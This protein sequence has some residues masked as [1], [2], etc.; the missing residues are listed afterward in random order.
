[1]RLAK[2][3]VMFL[4]LALIWAV[5]LIAVPSSAETAVN[6]SVGGSVLPQPTPSQQ[7]QTLPHKRDC[8]PL[9]VL[10]SQGVDP[11]FGYYY[12]GA[13]WPGMT[14]ALDAAAASVTVTPDLENLAYMLTFDSLW[15]DQRWDDGS[16]TANEMA[17]I[18]DFIATG[19]PVV[20][21]GENDN[22]IPW[23]DQILGVAGGSFAGETN[24]ILNT[25][26]AHPL[27]A[28][29]SQVEV[30]LA[31]TADSG[32]SLFDQNV[33]TIWSGA[34]NDSVLTILDV[35]AASEAWG[36]VDN[37]VF[38]TNVASWVACP[39][40][41][42]PQGEVLLLNE[43]CGGSA[44]HFP[45]ALSNLGVTFTETND[46]VA[47]LAELTGGTAWH[48]VIVDEYA[49]WLSAAT[50]AALVDY[51]A[52]GGRAFMSYWDW[53]SE[54]AL[55]AA[56]E[57]TAV[58]TYSAPLD[59]YRWDVGHPLFNVPNALPDLIPTDD[60]CGNDGGIFNATGGGVTIGGYT[61]G[62]A[63]D[64]HA[65]IVGN[66]GRTIAFGGMPGLFNGDFDSRDGVVDGL[67]LAENAVVWL[68][69]GHA[70]DRL[71]GTTGYGGTLSTLVE[72]DPITGAQ[73]AEIGPVGFVVNGLEFDPT[74]GKLFAGT[75]FGDP[76][77]NG[78]IEIDPATGAGTPIGVHGWGLDPA[79]IGL[80]NITVNAAGQMFGWVEGDDDLV[81]IDKGTGVA[82]VVGDSGLSTQEYGMSF[83]NTDTLFLVNGGGPYFEIDPVTGVATPRGNLG[84]HAHHG[85]FQP[86]TNLYYGLTFTFPDR[87]LV[88]ADLDGGSVIE[89]IPS[90]DTLHTLT[91]VGAVQGPQP[92]F[93]DGF[94]S[95]DTSAWSMTVY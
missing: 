46:D 70:E 48:A 52:S 23:N 11:A 56:F 63:A 89:V 15:V 21:I 27:T 68:M 5:A 55:T 75:S 25:T 51:I 47:F 74:T 62:P 64:Q 41:S 17:N 43:Q 7:T 16:L 22:W 40:G 83:D 54:P 57:A 94:E 6:P 44:E 13:S 66:D 73:V 1:M 84:Q 36:S 10:V 65:I 8:T 30:V 59:I 79:G 90:I 49:D 35:N 72:I 95:G 77:Y 24:G 61:P 86:G 29:V 9:H 34:G 50:A 3:S 19:R 18:V 45:I 2:T 42:G 78:L 14:A 85:D 92:F 69:G 82:T 93:E 60:T 81:I 76:A 38:F 20:M 67:E 28:G 87:S 26:T 58:G 33:M 32:L 88:V 53:E 37:T 71:L 80:T 31:G 91:F 12:G 4:S 39:E